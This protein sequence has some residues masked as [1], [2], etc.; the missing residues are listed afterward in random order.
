[1]LDLVAAMGGADCEGLRAGWLAQPANAISSLAYAAAGAWLVWRCRRLDVVRR[2]MLAGAGGLIAVGLGSAVYHGPQPGW[3]GPAHDGAIAW[4][5]L[6]LV[7][8]GVA[9]VSGTGNRRA[10]A[11]TLVSA[12]S[13][14]AAW[15]VPASAAYVAG[16]TGSSLCDPASLWQP[17]A[18]WHALSALALGLAIR[19]GSGRRPSVGRQRTS[20]RP[21]I[22]PERWP[23]SEQ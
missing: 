16:R 11:R 14:A 15:M 19:G 22:P 20:S 23:G 4:L 9:V 13:A 6:A 3:A 18:A 10:G 1:M 17:H 2:S 21:S 7:M 12:W 8:H 5:I